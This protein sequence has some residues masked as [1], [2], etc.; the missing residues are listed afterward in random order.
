MLQIK[1][2]ENWELRIK[3]GCQQFKFK[4]SKKKKI[5]LKIKIKIEIEIE[6]WK[7]IKK[8]VYKKIAYIFGHLFQKNHIS[9][10]V[11][12]TPIYFFGQWQIVVWI[13]T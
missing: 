8:Y 2:G 5:K 3:E 6:N 7:N 9:V 11:L 4:N 12:T 13:F 10:S 1:N